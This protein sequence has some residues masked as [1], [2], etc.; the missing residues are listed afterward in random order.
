MKK[1]YWLACLFLVSQVVIAQNYA[2]PAYTSKDIMLFHKGFVINYDKNTK[3][4]HWVAYILIGEKLQNKIKRSNKFTSDPLYPKAASN[5]DYAKSGYDKGHLFPAGSAGDSIIMRESFYFTNISPQ[6][7]SFNRGVWNKIEQT[8]RGW[9][10]DYDTLYVITGCV[11]DSLST[12]IGNG[13]AVPSYFYKLVLVYTSKEKKAIVFYLKNEKNETY[14]I[15][16]YTMSVRQLENILKIDFCVS[17][18]DSIENKIE[19]NLDK[20]KWKW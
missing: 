16:D 10:L 3:N 13:V 12:K 17:I 14:N 2:M 20:Q 1:I 8:V 11:V 15:S 4:A 5:K 7:P 9:A 19:S 18:P 6:I